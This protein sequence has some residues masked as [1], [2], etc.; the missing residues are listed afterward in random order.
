MA[1]RLLIAEDEPSILESLVFILGREGYSIATARDGRE[2]L[3]CLKTHGAPGL[4]I[5][6][7]MLPAVSGFEVLKAVRTEPEL[8]AVPVLMLTAKGQA[9]DRQMA[10]QMGANAFIAKP[11]SN[12]DV[13]QAVRRLAAP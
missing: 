10:E 6:D 5:L 1:T 8:E 2:A 3:E 13:V 7:V 11:F 12:Q 9:R 4:L